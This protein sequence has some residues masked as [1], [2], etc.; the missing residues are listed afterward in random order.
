MT[1]RYM[2][3]KEVKGIR[4]NLHAEKVVDDEVIAAKLEEEVILNSLYEYVK[5]ESIG[6]CD[7]SKVAIYINDCKENDYVL[8]GDGLELAEL[9]IRKIRV[10]LLD[11]FTDTINIQAVVMR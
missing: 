11:V 1:D 9:S 5:I 3:Y 8:L 7:G 6:Y 4:F 10:K 2:K